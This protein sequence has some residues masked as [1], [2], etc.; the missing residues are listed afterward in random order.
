MPLKCYICNYFDPKKSYY[1][2]PD[3][4]DEYCDR[5]G[6]WIKLLD[7]KRENIDKIR[8]CSEH[9]VKSNFL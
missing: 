4:N 7:A 1:R 2:I 6:L 9:F 5:S 8:I 3:R